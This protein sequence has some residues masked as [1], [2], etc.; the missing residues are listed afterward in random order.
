MDAPVTANDTRNRD[1]EIL[2]WPDDKRFDGPA[3]LN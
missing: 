2:A 3:C 1:Q